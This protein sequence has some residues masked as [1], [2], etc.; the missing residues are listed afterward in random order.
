MKYIKKYIPANKPLGPSM[1]STCNN[2]ERVLVD[3]RGCL[4]CTDEQPHVLV[5]ELLLR[6]SSICRNVLA[7]S[8][9]V[10]KVAAIAPANAPQRNV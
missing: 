10:V 7:T 1:R 6:P 9:G 2:I 3:C 8:A 5:V 4:I